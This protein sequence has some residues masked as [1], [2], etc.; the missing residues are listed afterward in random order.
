MEDLRAQQPPGPGEDV[1]PVSP[2]SHVSWE[3][4]PGEPPEAMAVAQATPGASNRMRP[5]TAG[6][7]PENLNLKDFKSVKPWITRDQTCKGPYKLD[8]S[9]IKS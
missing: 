4:L 1:S 3:L 9:R 5:V 6:P 8:A 7:D 2:L